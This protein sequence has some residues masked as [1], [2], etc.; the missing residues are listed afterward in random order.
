MREVNRSAIVP[1][2]ARAM[3]DL[4]NDVARYPEF[5]PWC[6]STRVI[7][8][9]SEMMRASI[10][11]S[12]GGVHK[13]FTTRNRLDAPER[14]QLELEEG[15]FRKLRGEWRFQELREDACK[16]TLHIEFEFSSRVMS[17]VFGPVFNSICESM[18]DA[19]VRRAKELYG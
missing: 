7:E 18:L 4:V 6:K 14:I 10:E 3:F 12:R 15:P 16:I 13:S 1:Y 8:E 17:V 19:F 11:V 2:P 9:N 5:L